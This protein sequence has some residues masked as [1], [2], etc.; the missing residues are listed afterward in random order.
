MNKVRA[1]EKIQNQKSK[2]QK[3]NFYKVHVSKKI[4]YWRYISF[5]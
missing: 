5:N 1:K 4:K 2:E 3:K